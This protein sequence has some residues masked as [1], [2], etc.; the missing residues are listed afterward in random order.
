MGEFGLIVLVDI[1]LAD[2]F[3]CHN[4]VK[5]REIF[6]VLKATCKPSL[7]ISENTSV[8]H[9]INFGDS[10]NGCGSVGR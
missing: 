8:T 9:P 4:L 1:L 3:I 2:L 7:S 10:A 5:T 6:L